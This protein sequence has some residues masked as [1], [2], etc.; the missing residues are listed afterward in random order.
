MFI[1]DCKEDSSLRRWEIGRPR[2]WGITIA[3]TPAEIVS[4]KYQLCKELIAEL[5][6]KVVKKKK[7][8][9]PTK[10]PEG[11]TFNVSL[12]EEMETLIKKK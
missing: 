7:K 2:I 6:K 11:G 10:W 5:Y 4:S 12:C 9:I 3:Q 8:K 1:P